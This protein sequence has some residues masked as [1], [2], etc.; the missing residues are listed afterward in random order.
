VSKNEEADLRCERLNAGA[1][2]VLVCG[3]HGYTCSQGLFKI[4]HR[5]HMTVCLR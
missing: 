3:L 4:F 5:H 1:Y 2:T